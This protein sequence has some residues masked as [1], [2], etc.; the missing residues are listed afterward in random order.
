MFELIP[1]HGFRR[2]V[3]TIPN[4][5]LPLSEARRVADACALKGVIIRTE[6]R[7][8]VECSKCTRVRFT[9]RDNAK[10]ICIECREDIHQQRKEKQDQCGICLEP[11]HPYSTRNKYCPKCSIVS[12]RIS[13]QKRNQKKKK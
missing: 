5:P 8:A 11:F 3:A 10:R 9:A 13:D 7:G 2:V 6:M 1:L 12:S 4:A